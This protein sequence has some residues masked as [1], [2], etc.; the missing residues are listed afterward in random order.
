MYRNDIIK[1]EAISIETIRVYN[2]YEIIMY[3]YN[4]RRFCLYLF[5]TLIDSLPKLIKLPNYHV[6]INKK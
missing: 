1:I 4:V 3:T 5:I 6:I 2:N